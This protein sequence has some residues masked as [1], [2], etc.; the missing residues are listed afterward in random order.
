MR[1]LVK[2]AVWNPLTL[3]CPKDFKNRFLDTLDMLN[4]HG[5]VDI[6]AGFQQL[7]NVPIAVL[8]AGAFG[9]HM[10]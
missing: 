9:I 1:R 2:Y 6:D 3:R 8:V 7:F 5:G 4:I 10:G